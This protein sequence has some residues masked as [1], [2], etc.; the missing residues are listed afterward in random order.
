M[1][2]CE[3]IF[4]GKIFMWGNPSVLSSFFTSTD[5]PHLI[6]FP[7]LQLIAL[8]LVISVHFDLVFALSSRFLLIIRC[9]INIEIAIIKLYWFAKGKHREIWITWIDFT[10]RLL[11]LLPS[12]YARFGC[13]TFN[14]INFPWSPG[15][16]RL[17]NSKRFSS[18]LKYQIHHW[19][20]KPK[21][22][23]T[24]LEN[25]FSKKGRF[26]FSINFLCDW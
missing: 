19:P 9:S 24:Y 2:A 12:H 8:S 4:F 21:A 1:R 20:T 17:I 3:W 11:Y 25:G 16:I 5:D 26:W 15:V 10:S 22:I 6:I 18:E 13:F 7:H 23:K 14:S